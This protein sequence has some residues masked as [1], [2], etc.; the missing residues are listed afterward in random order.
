MALPSNRRGW[1]RFVLAPTLLLVAVALGTLPFVVASMVSELR[2]GPN[3]T[4]YDLRDGQPIG[5]GEEVAASASEYLNVAIVDLNAVAG[6]ATLAISGN[7]ACNPCQPKRMTFFALDED[8]AQ[9]RGL[10]PFATVTIPAD[11]LAFSEEITLP[12]R[13][14]PTRYPFD[15]YQ[16][17]LGIDVPPPESE[18]A[19][20]P[21][22]GQVLGTLQSQLFRFTMAD[23][24]IVA[25]APKAVTDESL[26]PHR[27]FD[28]EFR[29][30]AYL[31]VLAVLL[32]L[33]VA[34]SS[35]LAL[36]TQPIDG[37]MLGVGG[38]ILAVWGVRSV[39]VPSSLDAVTAV[40]LALSG[41]ILLLL[42]GVAVRAAL[43]LHRRAGLHLPQPW[44]R[45]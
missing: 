12:V 11:E 18:P 22:S 13:G 14:I 40:D 28:L 39:L 23:P 7:R 15:T 27:E 19:G 32:V 41:V 36:L 37:L 44:K 2:G 20:G 33:L 35:A 4:L 5:A 10:P 3:H 31:P 9:R 29:R 45:T 25:A 21:T 30:P 38:L 1:E 8:A 42:V 16:L 26:A 34:A 24:V 43:H 17:R 6:S